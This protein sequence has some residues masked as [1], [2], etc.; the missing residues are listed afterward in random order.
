MSSFDSNSAL[1]VIRLLMTPAERQSLVNQ[2]RIL[3]LL[4]E[5]N[6]ASHE[7]NAQILEDGHAGLYSHVFAHLSDSSSAEV[8]AETHNILTMF[9][10]IE[11]GAAALPAHEREQLDMDE[12]TFSGFD[13]NNDDHFSFATFIIEKMGLYQE[14]RAADLNSHSSSSLPKY[15]GMLAVFNARSAGRT[16]TFEQLQQLAV[17]EPIW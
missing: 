7:V 10:A 1:I 14:L 12:L 11:N 6:R 2:F 8:G 15:R 17:A 16:L 5:D 3:A 4:D 13:G 9:R